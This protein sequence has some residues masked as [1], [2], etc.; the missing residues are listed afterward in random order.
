VSG[1][2]SAGQLGH[3]IERALAT[4]SG[5]SD[6]AWLDAFGRA[7]QGRIAP[8]EGGMR[9]VHQAVLR[10]FVEAGTAPG[11]AVLAEHAAPFEVSRVL[12]DLADGDFLYLD[13][14]GLHKRTSHASNQTCN[15]ILRRTCRC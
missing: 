12:G 5:R 2:P 4:D 3:V 1:S 10:S 14:A 15:V 11:I 13:H 6:P 9:A 8:A 7:G